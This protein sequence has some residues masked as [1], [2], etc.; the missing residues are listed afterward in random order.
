MSKRAKKP[1]DVVQAGLRLALLGGLVWMG[2]IVYQTRK[3]G[4]V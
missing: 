3:D 2:I 1:E 4:T